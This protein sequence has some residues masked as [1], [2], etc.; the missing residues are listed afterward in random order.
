M[1]V[2]QAAFPSG[3]PAAV[4]ATGASFPDALAADY[5]A[6]QVGGP[7]LLADPAVLPSV[8][9][10]ELTALGVSTVYVVGGTGA[11]S[12]AVAAA[13]GALPAPGAGVI[14]V[15]RVS[16]SNRSTRRPRSPGRSPPG[17]SAR[18]LGRAP[19]CWPPAPGSL[20]RWRARPPRRARTCRCC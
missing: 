19:P 15:V 9:A 3:A 8:T 2:A 16:G 18:W 1:E 5:L 14:K 17:R 7:V 13:I 10:T 4:V 11:V 20:T 6:G 12:A